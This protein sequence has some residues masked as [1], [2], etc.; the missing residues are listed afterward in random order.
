MGF[1]SPMYIEKVKF[2]T[3]TSMI[4]YISGDSGALLNMHIAT[5]EPLRITNNKM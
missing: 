2:K 5:K 3:K 4:W 1:D